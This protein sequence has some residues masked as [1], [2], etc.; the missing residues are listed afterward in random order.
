MTALREELDRLREHLRMLQETADR[1]G[2][3]ANQFAM[4]AT[5]LHAALTAA[6][7]AGEFHGGDHV[8][9]AIDAAID[10]IMVIPPPGG[11]GDVPK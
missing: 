2:K 10:E 1:N 3:R 8:I 4:E 9:S 7:N 6:R 5:L 11:A